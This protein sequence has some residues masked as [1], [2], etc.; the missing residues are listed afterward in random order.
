M[1]KFALS[2]VSLPSTSYQ[3]WGS[4]ITPSHHY[5]EIS[6]LRE[7]MCQGGEGKMD[8]MLV[9]EATRPI[10]GLQNWG[11]LICYPSTRGLRSEKILICDLGCE[12]GDPGGTYPTVSVTPHPTPSRRGGEITITPPPPPANTPTHRVQGAQGLNQFKSGVQS[13]FRQKPGWL[14]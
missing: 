3:G 11:S 2:E 9:T 13:K 7:A 12:P 4:H 6:G 8:G 1:F 10:R 5:V 14:G